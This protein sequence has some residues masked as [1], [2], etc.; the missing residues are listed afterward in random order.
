[1]FIVYGILTI[2]FFTINTDVSKKLK[3]RRFKQRFI[4]TAL[5]IHL[6]ASDYFVLDVVR[7]RFDRKNI[8]SSMRTECLMAVITILCFFIIPYI[9]A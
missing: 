8:R 4:K 3:Y 7:N 1:M 6:I 9:K 5:L 2:I